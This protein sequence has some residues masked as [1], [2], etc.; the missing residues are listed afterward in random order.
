MVCLNVALA[1]FISSLC[2][3]LSLIS[4]REIIIIPSYAIFSPNY[5]RIMESN[6]K[7]NVQRNKTSVFW[8]C[9]RA[10][11]CLLAAD[12]THTRYF[13]RRKPDTIVDLCQRFHHRAARSSLFQAVLSGATLHRVMCLDALDRRDTL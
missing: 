8:S 4:I 6:Y 5:S 12:V 10:Q 1:Q 2:H 9:P 7:E 13:T 3:S 11:T